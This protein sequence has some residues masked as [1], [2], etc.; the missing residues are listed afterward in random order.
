MTQQ[1]TRADLEAIARE[2]AVAHGLDPAL[3]CGVCEQESSWNPDATRYEDGFYA[4]YEEPLNL[5]S[6]EEHLRSVSWGV[7]QVMGQ[8][9]REFGYTG[10][11]FTTLC[12]EPLQGIEFGCRK[13]KRCMDKT[14]GD[15]VKALLMYNGGSNPQYDD[16]V[17][18]RVDKYKV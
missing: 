13:L 9:A 16:L 4:K 6:T 1:M 17:L 8:T 7:M 10:K 14:N 5:S 3:V 2:R 12:S 15:V 18:A 11:Y